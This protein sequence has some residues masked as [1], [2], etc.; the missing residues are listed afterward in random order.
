MRCHICFACLEINPS[1]GR[2]LYLKFNAG[3]G[4]CLRCWP[5]EEKGRPHSV[6]DLD[7]EE[8]NEVT[9]YGTKLRGQ[10]AP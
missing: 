10:A 2:K 9:K 3:E 8:S 1:I 6:L 7:A 4:P 5:R